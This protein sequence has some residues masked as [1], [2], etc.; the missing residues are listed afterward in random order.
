MDADHMER[1]L[2]ISKSTTIDLSDLIATYSIKQTL[3]CKRDSNRG[4]PVDIYGASQGER[5]IKVMES[6]FKKNY[7]RQEVIEQ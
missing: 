4:K 7:L 5:A 3:Y 6:Y 1:L 2:S